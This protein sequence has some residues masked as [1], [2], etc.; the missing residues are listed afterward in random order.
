MTAAAFSTKDLALLGRTLIRK[1]PAMAEELLAALRAS[2]L[3]P[4]ETDFSKLSLLFDQ[5]CALK[6]TSRETLL[7]SR[8][9]TEAMQLKRLFIGIALSM[10]YPSAI[11]NPEKLLR[12]RIGIQQ[13]LVRTLGIKKGNLSLMAH[14]AILNYKVYDS[15][16]QEVDMLTQILAHG[17]SYES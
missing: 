16:R 8:Y 1:H 4:L 10:Y 2:E 7:T 3:P 13:Q 14:E 5:F 9:N 11:A 17:K 12:K 15:F 6:E